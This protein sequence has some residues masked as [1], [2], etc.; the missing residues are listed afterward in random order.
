MC[1][2]LSGWLP[3]YIGAEYP[4]CGGTWTPKLVERTRAALG[5]ADLDDVRS[6]LPRFIFLRRGK[7]GG[8][9]GKFSREAGELFQRLAGAEMIALGYVRDRGW[10][11][12]LKP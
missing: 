6:T 9:E 4:K 8:W 1:Q 2:A 3:L 5:P 7:P 12:D 11:D 10:V